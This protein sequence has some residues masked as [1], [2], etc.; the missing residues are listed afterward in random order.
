MLSFLFSSSSFT[1][2][3]LFFF[4]FFNYSLCIL[5]VKRNKS[6]ILL[7]STTLL[8]NHQQSTDTAKKAHLQSSW[9]QIPRPNSRIRC[10]CKFNTNHSC[11]LF[12]CVLDNIKPVLR[13]VLI[14]RFGSGDRKVQDPSVQKA[15]QERYLRRLAW[16]SCRN[17]HWG[18]LLNL[19]PNLAQS[20]SS[21]RVK[22]S[23][24]VFLVIVYNLFHIWSSLPCFRV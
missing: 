13:R 16:R 5:S 4:F 24:A 18:S 15:Y 21:E 8:L 11:C 23:C 3:Q 19:S 10:C 20:L 1:P 2:P 7:W 6:K 22:K 17:L 14:L 12:F 9:I